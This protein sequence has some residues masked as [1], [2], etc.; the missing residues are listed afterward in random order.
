MKTIYVFGNLPSSGWLGFSL[1]KDKK[2]RKLWKTWGCVFLITPNTGSKVDFDFGE[3]NIMEDSDKFARQIINN[4][5]LETKKA[6]LAKE[7]VQRLKLGD[8]HD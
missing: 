2:G 5:L 7:T 1:G 8:K 3:K 6:D 4:I